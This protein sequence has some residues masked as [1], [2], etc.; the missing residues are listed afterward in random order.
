VLVKIERLLR[1]KVNVRLPGTLFGA[2]RLPVAVR[3]EVDAGDFRIVSSARDPEVAVRPGYLR[4]GFRA[5]ISVRPV[6]AG[7]KAPS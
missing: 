7:T 4:F 5:D 1:G 3:Q 2:F 6:P